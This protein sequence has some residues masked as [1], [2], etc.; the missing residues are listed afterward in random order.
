MKKWKFVNHT[1]LVAQRNESR[2]PA[3]GRFLVSRLL[4][5]YRR[6]L[7]LLRT[8]YFVLCT[9]KSRYLILIT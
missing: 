1:N 6:P 9:M 5:A 7:S 8:L 4:P 2:L 3:A